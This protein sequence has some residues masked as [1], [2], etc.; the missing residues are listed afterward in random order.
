MILK[1]PFLAALAIS[2]AL[3]LF[4]ITGPRWQLPTLAELL[5]PD[6][7][8]TLDAHLLAHPGPVAVR[9]ARPKPHKPKSVVP[10]AQEA[11]RGVSGGNARGSTPP[12]AEPA[13]PEPVAEAVEPP[14]AEAAEAL[15]ATT[16]TLPNYVR[17]EYRVTMGEAAFPIGRAM[18]EIRHDGVQYSMRND[19]ETTGIVSLFRPARIVNVSAGDVVASGL[20]PREYWVRRDNGKG[21][22]GHLDWDAGQVRLDNGRNYPLEAGTQDLLSMFGQLTLLAIG[23]SAVSLP[24]ATG[25]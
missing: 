25:K 21:E 15:P 19:A 22:A 23:G 14:L 17:I 2:F 6:P 4:V 12:A 1:R 7:G 20:R 18:Q 24:V 5:E 10:Q 8:P 11:S 3:H 16:M 9:P 13:P